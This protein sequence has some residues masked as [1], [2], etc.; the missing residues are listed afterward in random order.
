[1][2]SMFNILFVFAFCSVATWAFQPLPTQ[3]RIHHSV[4]MGA[5][6]KPSGFPST[7]AGK[8]VIIDR[9]KSLLEEAEMVITIP[10]EGITKENVDILKKTLGKSV[11][12]S[13]VKNTLMGIAVQGTSFEAIT[14]EGTLENQNIFLFIPEGEAKAASKAYAAWRKEV[15]RKEDEFDA[16]NA[17]MDNVFYTGKAIDIVT[18]LPTKL[19][20]I[21][22]IAQG[23]KAVPT[24]VGL[25]VNAV[26]NKV[27]R[28]F[29][30]LKDKLEA[31][32]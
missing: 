9:T 27:G 20:L 19:E 6:P 15:N 8:Q 10:S 12:A 22:K 7:K 24:K 21:T 2:M 31:D 5:A 28:A 13:C 1:M 4:Y 14:S 11:K 29:G 18:S 16:K 23:I 3:S 17:V 32:A 26:P 30:A 25:G